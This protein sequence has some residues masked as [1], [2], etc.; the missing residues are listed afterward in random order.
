MST[1]QYSAM[2]KAIKATKA[3]E[4]AAIEGSLTEADGAL[5]CA[6]FWGL[7]RLFLHF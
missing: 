2:A 4:K 7:G 1:Q 6:T 5:T 3:A